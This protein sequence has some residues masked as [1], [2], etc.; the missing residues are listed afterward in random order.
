MHI[1]NTNSIQNQDSNH[2]KVMPNIPEY[3]AI[4]FKCGSKNWLFLPTT[5]CALEDSV[6]TKHLKQLQTLRP[7]VIRDTL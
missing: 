1:A 3:S 4:L 2:Y 7:T 6:K 5:Y